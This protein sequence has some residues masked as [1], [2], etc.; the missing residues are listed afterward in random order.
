[1]KVL[2]GFGV[3]ILSLLL[4]LSLSVFGMAFMLKS[5]V[6]NPDFVASQ[7][8][9]IDISAL[10]REL[11]EKQINEQLPEEMSFLK[12]A[13][14]EVVDEQEPWLKEQADAAI[15][16][17]YDF[18]LG[19][20][21]ELDITISL[22]PLKENLRDSLWRKLN[23]LS[24]PEIAVIAEDLL[25]PYIDQH[26]DE[27]FARIPAEYLPPELAGLPAE[28]MKQYL[29]QDLPGFIE[30]VPDEQLPPEISAL[31]E[32]NLK[33]YYD[34]YYAEFA[35]QIPDIIELDESSIPPEVMEQLRQVRQYIG[36][37]Q[38]YYYY[39]IG[40]M[41]LLVAGIV[42]INRNVRDTTRALGIDLLIYG[43]MEFA[44][45]YLARKYM[46]VGMPLQGVPVSLQAWLTGLPGDILAPLQTFSI[47]VLIVGAVLLVVSFVYKP[48]A[49]E[50]GAG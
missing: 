8:D 33:P 2:K 20:S 17:G 16:D 50:D 7:V 14:Y 36:D 24:L 31:L 47:G 39:L 19:K 48:G 42:L 4:F 40:F 46:P 43:A 11:S 44:G 28:Q 18:L 3:A 23:E 38:T 30:L 34:Q 22:V 37:F 9:K 12:E 29:E 27:L 45:V 25:R 6:L 1:M 10:A 35:G 32:D 5:T 13:I 21:E 41:V 15:Y 49:A 26:F